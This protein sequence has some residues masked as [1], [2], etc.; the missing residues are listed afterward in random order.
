MVI[1]GTHLYV[2][3]LKLACLGHVAVDAS[4]TGYPDLSFFVFCH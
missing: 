4:L 2:L 1:L 3:L